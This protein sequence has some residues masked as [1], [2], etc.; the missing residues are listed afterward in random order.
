MPGATNEVSVGRFMHLPGRLKG[1]EPAG[2]SRARSPR[3][4][5]VEDRA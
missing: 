1:T 5:V 3:A 4:R 2:A